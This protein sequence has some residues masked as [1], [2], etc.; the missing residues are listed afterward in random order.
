MA[1]Q[2]DNGEGIV[3]SAITAQK[4][5]RPTI[6][7]WNRLEGRPRTTDFERALK[8][9]IR[10]PTLDAFK[11]MANGRVSEAKMQARQFWPRCT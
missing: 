8:A 4:V 9:E 3:A 1:E 10:D 6:T 5:Y 11:A 2:I 7:L